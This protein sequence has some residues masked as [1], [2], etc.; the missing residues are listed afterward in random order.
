[1]D[2]DKTEDQE[3]DFP[4]KQLLG[5]VAFAALGTRPDIAYAVSSCARFNHC[6]TRSHYTALKKVVCYLKATKEYGISFLV[7]NSPHTLE[8]YCD[9][10][11]GQDT[12]DR[13]SGSGVVLTI[14]NGPIAWLS[15]KQT[16]TASSTTEAEYLAAHIATKEILWNHRLLAGLGHPQRNPT[17]VMS[18]NQSAIRLILNLEY[19]QKT[20]HI[21][22]QYHVI[23]EHQA[24]GDI[25]VSYVSTKDQI[26]DIFTKALPSTRFLQLRK[27]LGVHRLQILA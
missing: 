7:T 2:H 11:Y 20:K 27:L 22:I 9:A 18:D 3:T 4:Y 14:N 8:A 24:N 23:R 15:R 17:A 13:K 12:H 26:A 6:F 10:N 19:D 5:S 21:D 16:C 1:M 25:S